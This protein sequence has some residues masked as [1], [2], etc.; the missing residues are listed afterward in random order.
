MKKIDAS[1]ITENAGFAEPNR[2][3]C[4]TNRTLSLLKWIQRIL[5][6]SGLSLLAIYGVVRLEGRLGSRAARKSFEALESRAPVAIGILAEENSSPETDFANW[7]QARLRAYKESFSSR[8]GAPL[9]VLQIPKIHLVVPL[10]DGTDELTLN[11]AV[12]RIAGTARPGEKG[13]LGIAGHRDGF[14]RGLKD[15]KAGDAIQL[16]TLHGMDTYVVDQIQIVKPD[17]VGVLRSR[18]FPSLT[19]ITCYP[20]YFVGSAPERYV[21]TATLKQSQ[22]AGTTTSKSRL[23]SQISSS[24]QVPGRRLETLLAIHQ[25]KL[26]TRVINSARVNH[27]KEKEK[28]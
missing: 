15:V 22:R 11:H 21:V 9:A 14:F 12:G 26:S 10:L 17:N 25:T 20:F 19:L 24:T 13:N 16:N 3:D 1:D 2:D 28:K 7:A 8:F 5:L 18:S 23:S 4:R 6:T 27:S